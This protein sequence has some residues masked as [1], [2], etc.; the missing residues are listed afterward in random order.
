MVGRAQ[1]RHQPAVLLSEHS[2]HVHTEF[3]DRGFIYIWKAN[4]DL[5]QKPAPYRSNPQNTESAM[6]ALSPSV[7][8]TLFQ[9]V[10]VALREGKPLGWQARGQKE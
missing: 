10:A 8:S 3:R 5:V 2:V 1:Y 6:A 4:I 7:L 9:E